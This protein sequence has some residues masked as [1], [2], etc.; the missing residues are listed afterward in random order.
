MFVL[1]DEKL[2]LN[3]MIRKFLKE[4][5]FIMMTDVLIY[6]QIIELFFIVNGDWYFG[7]I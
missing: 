5:V 7:K 6:F 3:G 2:K 4:N 1:E